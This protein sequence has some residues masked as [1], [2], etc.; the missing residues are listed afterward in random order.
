[1]PLKKD[2]EMAEIFKLFQTYKITPNQFYLLFSMKEG[3]SP[4]GINIHQDHRSLLNDEWIKET[5]QLTPK[6]EELLSRIESFFKIQKKKVMIQVLGTDSSV[7]I[8]EYLELFPN[9]LLP[10]G[11]R[12]RCAVGN[13]ETNFKWFFENYKYSWE[14][15]LKA[16]DMYIGEYELKSPRYLYMRTSQYFIRKMEK[17]HSIHSELAD[18]CANIESGGD[19]QV[20]SNFKE[21]VV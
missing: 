21:D 8:Q 14:T 15:I 4:M 9:I 18:Y 1:M 12:A 19:D 6:A 16:T 20:T 10:S 17:D 11:K 7:K 2:S 5:N 13:L 3:V